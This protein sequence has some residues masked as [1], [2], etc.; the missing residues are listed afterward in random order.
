MVQTFQ[1]VL[2]RHELWAAAIACIGLLMSCV[3]APPA[4]REG[5]DWYARWLQGVPCRA[6]C[7]EG[8]TPG[9]TRASDAIGIWAKSPVMRNVRLAQPIVPTSRY[10]AIWW[11]WT[12]GAEG[13]SATFDR[14]APNQLVLTIQPRLASAYSL[15]DVMSAYGEPSHVVA[16]SQCYPD[17]PGASYVVFVIFWSH[18][19]TL[20]TQGQHLPD[21]ASRAIDGT[22]TFDS[23]TFFPSGLDI[24]EWGIPRVKTDPTAAV[25]WQGPQPLGFYL[26]DDTKGPCFPFTPT[27]R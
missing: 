13:G 17:S 3:S 8:V 11:S 5:A 20:S 25:P 15:R 4:P 7:W 14:T 27:P 10:G 12:S 22:S 1:C 6:P 2:R 26:H 21:T 19:F 16:Q 18:G 24:K 23:V 9:E